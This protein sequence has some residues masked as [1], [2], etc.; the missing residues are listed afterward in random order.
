M[1]KCPKCG[2]IIDSLTML[3]TKET[4]FTVTYDEEMEDL[5]FIQIEEWYGNP[6]GNVTKEEY[7]CPVCK[8]V[9][10]N[11][12]SDAKAFLSEI[13]E[14]IIKQ[15]REQLGREPTENEIQTSLKSIDE[16]MG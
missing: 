4:E 3:E 11:N 9:I 15:L 6:T 13:R 14:K 16:N 8:K 12:A 1:P 5:D 10:F 2:E 7:S